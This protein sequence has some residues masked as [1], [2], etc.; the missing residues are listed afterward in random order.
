MIKEQ[1]IGFVNTYPLW[2]GNTF[3]I[4]QFEFPEVDLQGLLPETIPD[5]IRLGHQM[6]HVFKQLVKRSNEYQVVLHNLAVRQGGQTLGEIDFILESLEKKKLTHVELAYKFYIIDPEIKDPI[7]RLIGP[8]RRDSFFDKMEKIKH[9]QFPLLHSE[10]GSKTLAEHGV[11]HTQVEHQCCFKGQ[12]FSKYGK[13]VIDIDGVNEDCLSGNWLRFDEFRSSDFKEGHH[14]I[15]TK[16]EW[17][18]EP[19]VKVDWKSYNAIITEID[20]SL[21]RERAPMIWWRS[22]SGLFE[23]I[24]VV[25]W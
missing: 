14:Y 11:D 25:W 12:L 17:V 9:S 21:S 2:I 6:E 22:P 10:E 8:N 19:H 1:C 24:F 18:V 15:P 7:H 16:S 13:D 3:G 5:N 4:E 20:I 23:K